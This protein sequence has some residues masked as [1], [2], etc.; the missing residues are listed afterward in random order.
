MARALRMIEVEEKWIGSTSAFSAFVLFSAVFIAAVFQNSPVSPILTSFALCV[1]VLYLFV[2]AYAGAA[3]VGFSIFVAVFH[4]FE[5]GSLA[6]MPAAAA[7]SLL[8][9]GLAIIII[10]A[11][12]L[13]NWKIFRSYPASGLLYYSV[14]GI[15]FVQVS[16]WWSQDLASDRAGQILFLSILA[17]LNGL[18]DFASIGLTRW[19]LRLGLERKLQWFWFVD[20]AGAISIF[21]FLG[22]GIIAIIHWNRPQ[23]GQTLI[24][25]S[26]IFNEFRDPEARG[27]YWWLMFILFSTLI[28]TVLHGMIAAFAAFTVIPSG[29]R[30]R[31]AKWLKAAP[32]DAIA[33]RGGRLALSFAATLAVMVPLIAIFELIRWWPAIL[34]TTIW[35]FESWAKLIGAI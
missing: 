6:V 24:D 25:L 23:D 22:C 16:V 10:A 27:Q 32:E 8:L 12:G 31:I 4:A 17:L 18:T 11:L 2:P 35:V 9:L 3:V 14:A 19:S 28:P 1:A 30:T 29:I 20:L 21:A 34:N 33:A 13:F 5:L 26:I 15:I 7:C